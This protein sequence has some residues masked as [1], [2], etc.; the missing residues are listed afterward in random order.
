MYAHINK[1]VQN[2]VARALLVDVEANAFA[3]N[4]AYNNDTSCTYIHDVCLYI[5]HV[6]I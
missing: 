4:D 5:I 1:D 6:N 3:N 2:S